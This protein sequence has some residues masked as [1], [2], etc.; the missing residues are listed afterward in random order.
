MFALG[1]V[2]SIS[3]TCVLMLVAMAAGAAREKLAGSVS[4]SRVMNRLSGTMFGALGVY[5]LTS[6]ER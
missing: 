6:N 2:F 3:G 5:L 1:A 4:F